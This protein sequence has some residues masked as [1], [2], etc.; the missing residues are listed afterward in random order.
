ME[1]EQ[2]A[3]GDIRSLD[4]VMGELLTDGYVPSFCTACYRLGRTGEHFMEFAIPGFIKR[5]CTPNALT[6]LLEYLLDY[7]SPTTLEA[8]MKQ[9]E[10]ELTQLPDDAIKQELLSRME[11]IRSGE[12][13]LAF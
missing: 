3:L 10:A 7:A 12:R 5:Y 4:T 13:D 11:R 2:F 8:G 6:T 9:I 1:R